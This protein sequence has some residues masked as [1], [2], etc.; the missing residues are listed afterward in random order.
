MFCLSETDIGPD[1]NVMLQEYHAYKSCRKVSASNIFFGGLCIFTSK[2][3]KDGV[4]IVNNSHQDIIWLKLRKEF[5][6]L[7][8]HLFC[9][10]YISPS[11]SIYFKNNDFDSDFLFDCIRQNCAD[12]MTKGDILLMGDFNAYIPNNA[13]D[14]IYHPDIPL[15]RNTVEFCEVNHNGKL[16]L[17]MCKNVDVTDK[18]PSVSDYAVSNVNLLS[19]VKY[20]SVSDLT[21]FSDHCIIKVSLRTNFSVNGVN[22]VY[23]RLPPVRAKVI[24]KISIRIG[25]RIP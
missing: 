16:L 8:I 22:D 23:F 7:D 15:K 19:K 9:F 5:F 11:N 24:S 1:F 25:W 18:L 6:K 3:I 17:E 4:K 20:F 2:L 14:Y 13:F 21:R 12:F 10:C